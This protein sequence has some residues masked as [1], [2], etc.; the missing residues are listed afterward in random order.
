MTEAGD[1]NGARRRMPPR[2]HSNFAARTAMDDAAQLDRRSSVVPSP[3][4]HEDTPLLDRTGQLADGRTSAHEEILQERDHGIETLRDLFSKAVHT[5]RVKRGNADHETKRLSTTDT[6][7]PKPG[8]FPRPVGGTGK[9]GTFNGVFVPT[10]LNV[11]SILMFLRFGFILGQTGV[12]GMMGESNACGR[13]FSLRLTQRRHACRLLHHQPSHHHVDFS[14]CFQRHRQRGR[15]V[16]S[17]LSQPRSRVRW[18]YRHRVLSRD[19]LQYK[20]E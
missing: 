9:L 14:H 4:P 16:L 11:L 5:L 7:K 15:G 18:I 13:Q 3:S 2:S 10:T 20:Y 6:T 1:G 19:G 17:D 12:L 8:A